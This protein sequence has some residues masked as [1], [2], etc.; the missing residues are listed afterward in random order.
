ML[1]PEA[2]ARQD[3]D[4]ALAVAGWSVQ[5]HDAVDLYAARGVVVREFPLRHGHGFADYRWQS[6][7]R[8]SGNSWWSGTVAWVARF[9]LCLPQ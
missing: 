1:T 5:D 3:I 4:D 9:P 2:A 8:T 6:R 7:T